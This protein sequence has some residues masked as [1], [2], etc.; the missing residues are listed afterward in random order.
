MRFAVLKLPK[1]G[2]PLSILSSKRLQK[3]LMYPCLRV[4]F[5]RSGA[6]RHFVLPTLY[7]SNTMQV[8]GMNVVQ[9][10]PKS[11]F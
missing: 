2:D 1:I 11:L 7:I 3:Q 4:I 5:D 9:R 6:S 8:T 10:I